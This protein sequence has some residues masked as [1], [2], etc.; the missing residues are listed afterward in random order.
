[1][2]DRLMECCTQNGQVKLA[3]GHILPEIGGVCKVCDTTP[4]LSGYVGENFV[5][6]L[7]DSGCSGVV[8]KRE[9]VKDSE[10]TGKIQKCVLIDGTVRQVEEA[11]KDIDTPFYTGKVSALC[12]REPVYDLIIGN[13]S[14]VRNQ[15]EPNPQWCRRENREKCCEILQAVQTRGQK[16][17]E[18]KGLKKLNVT[19]LVD[20]E[21]TVNKMKEL[22]LIDKN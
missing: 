15:S 17:K 22:Q 14:G 9:L 20:L 13:I 16:A 11:L 19:D 12:M 10:L 7:R 2:T 1:M 6:I 5:N 8:V 21:V 18:E 3:C 4:V